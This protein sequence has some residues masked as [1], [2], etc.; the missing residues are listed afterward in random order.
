MQTM[1]SVGSSITV[2]TQYHGSREYT[3]QGVVVPRMPWLTPTQFAVATGNPDFPKA[4]IDISRV[5]DLKIVS[6]S[7]TSVDTSSTR[8]FRVTSKSTGK[9]YLV[10]AVGGKISCTCT[11]FSYRRTCKHA[12]AVSKRIAGEN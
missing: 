8:Q 6:G 1:P 4:V 12:Q 11:G 5:V 10:S 2:R 9:S 3:T 7:T